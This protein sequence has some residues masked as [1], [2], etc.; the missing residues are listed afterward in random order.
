MHLQAIR[1]QSERLADCI[2]AMYSGWLESDP[3][4]QQAAVMVTSSYLLSKQTS[5][6]RGLLGDL[7]QMLGNG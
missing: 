2:S 7:F 1:L 6:S 3:E 5:N 4:V